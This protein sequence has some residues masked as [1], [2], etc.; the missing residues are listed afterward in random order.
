VTKILSAAMQNG[1]KIQSDAAAMALASPTG[2][3]VTDSLLPALLERF[4]KPA[5][6]PNQ[7][8]LVTNVVDLMNKLRPPES[9]PKHDEKYP[10]EQL[11]I[12]KDIFGVDSL[13]DLIKRMNGKGVSETP[14]YAAPLVGLATQLPSILNWLTQSAE[15]N[16]KRAIY[17]RQLPANGSVP[18]DIATAP[19]ANAPPVGVVI[20]PPSAPAPDP[21][22]LLVNEIERYFRAGWDGYACAVKL[23]MDMPQAAQM[24]GAILADPGQLEMV[25]HGVPQLNAL[26]QVEHWPEWLEEFTLTMKGDEADD[27]PDDTSEVAAAS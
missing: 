14:W 24:L 4:L 16:F 25:V 27:T 19:P 18:A 12:V 3:K 9:N 13:P 6:T 5:E 8:E 11:G 23:L 22:Q 20:P 17:L 10:L 2:N 26:S 1:L 7:L 15:Q 21:M